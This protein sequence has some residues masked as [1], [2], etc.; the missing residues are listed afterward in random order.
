[1]IYFLLMSLC[2]RNIVGILDKFLHIKAEYPFEKKL[3]SPFSLKPNTF[4]NIL[5]YFILLVFI[6]NLT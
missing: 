4:V 2:L 6:I 3:N 1:M 5:F